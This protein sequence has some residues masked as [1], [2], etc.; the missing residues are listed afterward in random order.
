MFRSSVLF[1][2]AIFSILVGPR[3]VNAQRYLSE[4][5]GSST[6]KSTIAT[7]VLPANL[8]FDVQDNRRVQGVFSIANNTGLSVDSLVANGTLANNGNCN[9]QLQNTI[10]TGGLNLIEIPF[11]DQSFALVGKVSVTYGAVSVLS[12]GKY[13]GGMAVLLPV[14][15]PILASN[16]NIAVMV[17]RSSLTGTTSSHG[18]EITRMDDTLAVGGRFTNIGDLSGFNFTLSASPRWA[19]LVGEDGNSFI[20]IR[21]PASLTLT[22]QLAGFRGDY[23]IVNA[24]GK[25]LDFGTVSAF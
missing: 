22:G 19:Y 10:S 7:A 12:R 24:S 13:T 14:A 9:V 8:V 15:Q 6:L 21:A 4:F 16:A 18:L 17:T 5:V 1:V 23:Q 25:L 3:M 2:V 11:D 20:A